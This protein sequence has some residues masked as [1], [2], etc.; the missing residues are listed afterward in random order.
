M[1]AE[2]FPRGCHKDEEGI[3]VCAVFPEGKQCGILLYDAAGALQARVVLP[4]RF[5]NGSV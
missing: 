2:P 4:A 1:C 3:R 5:R